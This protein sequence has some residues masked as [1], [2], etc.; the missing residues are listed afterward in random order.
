MPFAPANRNAEVAELWME[1]LLATQEAGAIGSWEWDLASGRMVWSAQ[2]FRLLGLPPDGGSDLARLIAALHEDSRAAGEAALARCAAG[3]SPIRLEVR[4]AASDPPRWLVLVGQPPGVEAPARMLG[5]AIDSTVRRDREA[6]IRDNDALLRL[7]MQAGGMGTWE[8]DL[9]SRIGSWSAEAAV[10][11]GY[12]PDRLRMTAGEWNRL[13]H[14]DDRE[15]VAEAFRIALAEARDFTAEYRIVRPSDG[16]VCWIAVRAT[17]ATDAT[18][19]PNRIVGVA[20]DVTERHRAEAELRESEESFRRVFE[21]SPLGKVTAGP[22]FRL[23]SVNPALCRMLGYAVEEMIGKNLLDIVHPDDRTN[24][25]AMGQALVHGQ[26]PQIQM[27]ERFLHRSGAPIWV[28]VNVGP[29]RDANGKFLYSLGIIED[30]DE[31][32]RIIHALQESEQRLRELNERLEQQ[33]EDRAR[34]LASSRA[35][36]QAFFENSP[37]WLTLQRVTP[38]GRFVFADINPTCEEAYGLSRGQV[39]GRSVEEVLGPEQA[40]TPVHYFREC[41]RTGRTQRY[42]T[43][44]TMAGRHHVIDVVAVLVPSQHPG[45]ERFLITTARDITEREQLQAQLRHSQKMDAIGQLT[46]GV[47]HDFNNMLSVIMGC[48]DLARRRPNPDLPKLMGHILAA[49]E[50]GVGLTRHLLSLSRRRV[51]ERRVLDVGAELP[52]IAEMLRASL[53]GDIILEIKLA[54]TVWPIEV[55][56]GELDVALLNLAV[57]ARDA[58]HEGGRLT[59]DIGNRAASDGQAARVAFAVRDTGIGMPEDVVSQAFEPFFTTKPIGA[60]TGLGL[61]QVYSFAQDAGGS[62]EIDSRPGAGTCV[63]LSLPPSVGIPTLASRDEEL[64]CTQVS[65][66]ILLVEDNAEVAEITERMLRDMGF[67]VELC[68]RAGKALDRLRVAQDFDLLLTDVVMPGG[69][70]GID[71]A[72]SVQRHFPGLPVVL[73][74]GYVSAMPPNAHEFRIISK[75]VSY[76]KLR[77]ALLAAMGQREGGQQEGAGAEPD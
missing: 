43:Q 47:A 37:D 21:Q 42:V 12:P 68:D 72:R 25:M 33:V 2:M 40:Q 76:A 77:D 46:G 22:D 26:Q 5:M 18:G 38:D 56:P 58:M 50:R 61:S 67:E 74:S 10:M 70:N 75:P 28:R 1:H 49:G 59:L 15:T 20:E 54:E 13:R 64:P 53:R 19:R 57:N 9:V 52:R 35:Q 51:S 30:I 69:V 14:P 24:C 41:L 71:L 45:D 16:A 3:P 29:I 63:T 34:E 66:R 7:A 31:R 8:M 73:T 11:H 62:V 32:R 23:R 17:L 6:V 48:A 65:G 39:V 36:M 44:R 55:D 60:G 27:E 4:I